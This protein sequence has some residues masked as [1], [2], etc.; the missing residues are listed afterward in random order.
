M[1]KLICL[2]LL[3]TSFSFV[4]SCKK[5]DFIYKSKISQL[6]QNILFGECSEFSIFCFTELVEIP[7][8]DDG[9]VGKT[10]NRLYFKLKYKENNHEEELVNISF[11][12]GKSSFN[13][14]FEYKPISDNLICSISV[15]NI[16]LNK[17]Y[18]IITNENK[19]QALTLNSIKNQTTIPYATAITSLVNND[20]EIKKIFDNDSAEI[21]IRLI[22]NDSYDYWYV[23]VCDG[24]KEYSFLVD[25]QNGE[26][27]ARKQLNLPTIR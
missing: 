25:G 14:Q 16:S 21:R 22:N 18:L 26:L 6:R 27:L 7:I 19:R 12:I 8:E 2:I 17:L 5:D 3:L 15:D 24:K 20:S 9:I 11:N 23:G 1:K 4:C 13:G 10:E